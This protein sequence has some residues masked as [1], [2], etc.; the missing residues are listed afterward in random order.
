MGKKKGSGKKKAGKKSKLSPE[1]QKALADQE[2]LDAHEATLKRT[3]LATKFLRE[4]LE[5]EE[6]NTRTSVRQL[7]EQWRLILRRAKADDLRSEIEILSQ[8]F[9]RVLD[10]RDAII[11]SLLRELDEASLQEDRMVQAHIEQVDKLVDMHENVMDDLHG[12]FNEE[13]DVYQREFLE[14]RKRVIDQHEKELTNI[15]DVIFAMNLQHEEVSAEFQS[16][17]DSKR[18]DVRTKNM[19]ERE[20]LKTELEMVLSDLWELFQQ[21]LNNYKHSTAEKQA[22]FEKLRAND[23]KSASIIERQTRKLNRLAE[24]VNTIKSRMSNQ[25]RDFEQRNLN[26]KKEKE[27]VLVNFQKLKQ[28]MSK[29]RNQNRQRLLELTVESKECMDVLTERKQLAERVLKQCE[30]CR[31]LETE[32]EKVLPFYAETVTPEELIAAGGAPTQDDGS[33]AMGTTATAPPTVPVAHT[34]TDPNAETPQVVDTA[35]GNAVDE[36]RVLDNFWKRYNKALLDKVAVQ[37]ERAAL[38]DENQQLR[39]LLRQYMDGISVSE[40]VLQQDNTLLIVN[41]RTNAPM[42]QNIPVGDERVRVAARPPVQN[43]VL[44]SAARA[45]GR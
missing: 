3:E 1:E 20:I 12:E 35:T 10:R 5:Q 25:Q 24:K 8:T 9:E 42:R 38:N 14:E 43:L 30:A 36:F 28:G 11:K 16:E 27:Q 33:V 6:K 21:A 2:A 19:E 4:K 44:T 23:I 32:E 29:S 17:Y 22:E 45:A 13:L 37:R 26:L 15:K 7:D 40:S 18:D 34:A 39:S 31:L 41:G